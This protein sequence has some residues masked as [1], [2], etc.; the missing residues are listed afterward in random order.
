ML[1]SVLFVSLRDLQWRRRRFLIGVFAAG[2]VFALALVITGISQSFRNEVNR[3]VGAID[4][5]QWVVSEKVAGP[6]TAS[7]LIASALAPKIAA[8]PGVKQASAIVLLRNTLKK[9]PTSSLR[10]IGMIGAEPGGVG[11]PTVADGRT[12]QRDGEAVVD[13]SLNIGLGKEITVAGSP[14]RVVGRTDGVTYFAGIPAVFITLRDAQRVSLVGQPL[15][16]AIVVR[17]HLAQA[18]VTTHIVSN[19]TVRAD[20]RRPLKNGAGTIDTMRFLLWVV[21]A[22]IIGSIL[23]I[24]AIERTRDFAVFKAI[25]V[26]GRSLALGMAIQAIVLALLATVVAIILSY[27]LGP[28]MPIRVE[29]PDSALVVMPAVAIVISVIASLLGMRRAVTVDPA[30]AFGG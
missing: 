11:S 15:A 18:P 2:L 12:L 30:M 20:L 16:S 6:F 24:H 7:T 22:G 25:G 10:D 4:A 26:T 1:R 23:Y 17:G 5:D 14:F 13:K 9:T 29:V 3:T 21:A 19:D 27:V 28:L 8:E